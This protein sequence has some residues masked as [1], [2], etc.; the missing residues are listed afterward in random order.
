MP[1]YKITVN[2]SLVRCGNSPEIYG[3]EIGNTFPFFIDQTQIL[4]GNSMLK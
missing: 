3:S 4:H 2:F 1:P